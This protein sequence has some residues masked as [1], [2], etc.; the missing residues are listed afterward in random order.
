MPLAK[1]NAKYVGHAFIQGAG[2]A[3]VFELRS[4]LS[5]TM[6]DFVSYEVIRGYEVLEDQTI[7]I[8]EDT[9]IVFPK[10]VAVGPAV[11]DRR[12]YRKTEVVYGISP[13]NLTHEVSKIKGYQRDFR[14]DCIVTSARVRNSRARQLLVP[15]AVEYLDEDLRC[16]N[17]MMP[18]KFALEP[19]FAIVFDCP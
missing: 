7:T 17:R 19:S 18:R 14:Y 6:H 12:I 16:F 5:H 4:I 15:T 2:F 10:G 13:K 9:P 3:S 8:T 1:H 11:V